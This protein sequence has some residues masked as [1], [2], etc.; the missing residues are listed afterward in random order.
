M[1]IR[2]CLCSLFTVLSFTF[3]D[4]PLWLTQLFKNNALSVARMIRKRRNQRRKVTIG[5]SVVTH[6]D[7]VKDHPAIVDFLMDALKEMC[8][9]IVPTSVSDLAFVCTDDNECSPK[10]F[11]EVPTSEHELLQGQAFA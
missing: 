10:V 3:S 1:H 11:E 4:E 6:K 7:K 9:D 5:I 2:R 8:L